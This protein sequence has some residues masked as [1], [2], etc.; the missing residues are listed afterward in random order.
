MSELRTVAS[1]FVEMA[2]RMV[3]CTLATVD[4]RGRP[5]SR[6]VHTLW[7]WDENSLVGW[8]GSLVTPL[9]RAHLRHNPYVS[10]NYWDGAEAYDT[11]V[12]ECRAELLLDEA[13][14]LEGWERFKSVL[15]PLG[16]DPAIIPQWKDGPGSAAWG[17]L[18]LKPWRLRVFR[19]CMRR[20]T[21]RSAKSLPGRK[22]RRFKRRT[23]HSWRWLCL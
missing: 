14:R 4:R 18:R 22:P 16:Y 19:A 2:N 1:A 20:Q 12:A 13:S 8:V 9:K 6:I 7:E 21:A 10:C 17:V 23:R 5:R 3:Y 15:P 11:C